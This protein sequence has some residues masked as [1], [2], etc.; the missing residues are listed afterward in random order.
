VIAGVIG[1]DEILLGTGLTLVTVALW[2]VLGRVSLIVPGLVI[3]W[4]AVP[5]RAPFVT[6][7]PVSDKDRRKT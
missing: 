2:P 4:I 6:R 3:L 5:E 7:P 1:P